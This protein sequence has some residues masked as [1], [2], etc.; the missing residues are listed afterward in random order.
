MSND[1]I[2]FT[3]SDEQISKRFAVLFEGYAIEHDKAQEIKRTVGGGIDVAMGGNFQLI[4][5]V[6][7]APEDAEDVNY[8]TIHDLVDLYKLNNPSGTPTN[9]ITYTD[10]LE[11]EMEVYMI[12]KLRIN[13]MTVVVEGVDA[14]YI[15]PIIL[16][17][18][19][20]EGG[21]LS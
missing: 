10:H 15:A 21:D 14:Y 6:I 7:K 19:P 2:T 11:E 8:G 13:T 4:Y 20:S 5:L 9:V 17:V 1:Y 18:I 16:Q 12:G 3:T